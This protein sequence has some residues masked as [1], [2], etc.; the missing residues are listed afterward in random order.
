[1]FAR[2]FLLRWDLCFELRTSSV[3]LSWCAVSRVY[4]WLLWKHILYSLGVKSERNYTG[5]KEREGGGR[6]VRGKEKK[7]EMKADWLVE[8][9]WAIFSQH[10]SLPLS[11]SLPLF[12][13]LSL[14]VFSYH[15]FPF[16]VC[17]RRRLER[18][19]QKWEKPRE[20]VE[21]ERGVKKDKTKW[22]RHTRLLTIEAH[23]TS[24][25][26]EAFRE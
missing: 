1:M 24:C 25:P 20:C 26:S 16:F 22:T 13:S 4:D 9:G 12:R 2:A 15:S 21:R 5:V 3:A 14:S 8:G 7:K 6:A 10:H 17:W 19:V 23:F 11:L 18:R